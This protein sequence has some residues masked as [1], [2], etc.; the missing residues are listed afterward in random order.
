V[1]LRR[2]AL[3]TAFAAVAAAA[4]LPPIQTSQ[5]PAAIQL[6]NGFLCLTFSKDL[7]T[8]TAIRR[9][10]DGHLQDIAVG[11]EAYYWDSNTEPDTPPAGAEVPNKG[12]FRACASARPPA[13][14]G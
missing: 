1:T 14:H 10:S 9:H 11:P 2:V 12:Y 5:D 7:G 4:D 3:W 8:F 13:L 6:D